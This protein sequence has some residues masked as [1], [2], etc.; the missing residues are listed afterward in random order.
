MW[1]RTRH[2]R[3]PAKITAE[4]DITGMGDWHSY[5]SFTV[6]GSLEYQFPEAFQAYWIRF[7]SD[8]KATISAQLVYQ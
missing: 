5:K 8:T 4:V 2:E 7:R 3:T 6:T 1:N